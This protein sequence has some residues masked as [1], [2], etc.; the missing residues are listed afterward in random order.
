MKTFKILGFILLI[1]SM[2]MIQSCEEKPEMKGKVDFS[3][4]LSDGTLKSALSDSIDDNG[5]YIDSTLSWHLLVSII[6]VD[7]SVVLEDEII[8]LYA[9]G[10]GFVSEK[11]ELRTGEYLLEKFMVIGPQG[12]VIYAAPVEGSPKAYLVNDPLPVEFAVRPNQVSHVSPEVLYVGNSNPGEFGYASFSFTV[13]KPVIAYVMAVDDNPLYERPSVV[14]PAVMTLYAPDG[15]THTYKLRAGVNQI[16][17]KS[18][19]E[20]FKVIVENPDYRPYEGEIRTKQLMNSTED[21]P[22]IFNLYQSAEMMLVLQPGPDR[23]KD[24]MIT[25]L[26]NNVNYGDHPFFE[27]SFLSE[28]ILTVMR[29]KQSLIQF[30]VNDLPKGARIT[31]VTLTLWFES[32]L[33]DTLYS[34]LD[35]TLFADQMLVLQQIVE[36]WEEHEVTWEN[37]PS[38]IE[39]N[40]VFIPMWDAL[41]ANVRTYDVTSLF[42]P[43]QEIAAPNYGMMFKIYG[44]NPYP[45]GKQFLSSDFDIPEMRPKLTVYYTIL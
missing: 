42:V 5:N 22:V 30:N 11:I 10:S 8:P 29:T 35:N 6:S 2:G 12:D 34:D 16:L 9:F 13:V 43:M 14:I 15:W 7:G 17:V 19:Y 26:N 21:N 23:G 24:A 36:P 3:V 38:T 32:I 33:W 39:A 18:G 31:K 37:Q 20:Y 45:G 44:D 40:Q 4:L 41:S 28:P 25:D 27:A 1:L